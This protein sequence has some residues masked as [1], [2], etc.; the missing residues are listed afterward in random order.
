MK[1]YDGD[2]D[3]KLIY[4]ELEKVKANNKEICNIHSRADLL[5]DYSSRRIRRP[6]VIGDRTVGSDER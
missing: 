6:I 2:K 5:N 4:R 1:C 3:I